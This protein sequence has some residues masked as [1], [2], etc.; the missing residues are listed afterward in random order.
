LVLAAAL[1]ALDAGAAWNIEIVQPNDR[2]IGSTASLSYDLVG[3]PSIAYMD[4]LAD[5]IRVATRIGGNWSTETIDT[6]SGTVHLRHAHDSTG[7]PAVLFIK[8]RG[9]VSFDLYYSEKVSGSW[10]TERIERG[11]R[12]GFLSLAF[13]GSDT[14][15]V[16]YRDNNNKLVFASQPGSS[17]ISEVVAANV[18][19][20]WPSL[21]YD[22]TGAPAIAYTEDQTILK[23][24]KKSGSSWSIETITTASV[25]LSQ[26][27]LVFD[28]T[29][30]EATVLYRAVPCDTRLARKSG[31]TW[32]L[33]DVASGYSN[34]ESLAYDSSGTPYVLYG[35]CDVN[36]ELWVAHKSGGGWSSELVDTN[37]FD[38]SLGAKSLAIDGDD[39]PSFSYSKRAGVGAP[40]DL[41]FA[42]KQ[43]A[44]IA[45]ADCDDSNDCTLD[46]CE[47]GS[48]SCQY[49]SIADNTSC[50]GVA[51]IC[52]AGTCSTAVCRGDADCDDGDACSTDVC[53]SPDTCAAACENTFP[54]CGPSDGCCAPDC[55]AGNDPDCPDEC[56]PT[57]SKEKGPRCNDDL[58]NDCDGLIDGADPD[59]Q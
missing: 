19:A 35:N 41:R 12:S 29:N 44:C 53:M 27:D 51:G 7:K 11:V 3:N 21:A 31:G 17:W 38:Q 8:K 46:T 36:N 23:L 28:P 6:I 20:S 40:S 33:E 55:D 52:C 42:S 13:D 39:N 24:A 18:E 22:G 49:E 10:Q 54:G 45:D 4:H 14:P 48:G 26:P 25:V 58:D 34:S 30:G 5:E 9:S 37:A 32:Q 56:V 50:D 2:E 16:V 1:S 43:G 15:T 59:C 57:H 47:L